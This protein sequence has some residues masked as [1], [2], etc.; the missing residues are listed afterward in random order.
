MVVVVVVVVVVDVV[1]GAAG[2]RELND[3][4]TREK[5]DFAFNRFL[6]FIIK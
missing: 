3:C 4:E 2:G 5:N 1:G 6:K